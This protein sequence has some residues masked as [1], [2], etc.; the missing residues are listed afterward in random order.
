MNGETPL[1]YVD[2][3]VPENRN[4][5]RRGQRHF[6]SEEILKE[7]RPGVESRLANGSDLKMNGGADREGGDEDEFAA[8]SK[9]AFEAG[10]LEGGGAVIPL[11][12]KEVNCAT[13]AL[14]LLALWRAKN[15]GEDDS[16]SRRG[17]TG[18][19]AERTCSG[20]P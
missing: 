20:R 16:I 3:K 15:L 1:S 14:A 13:E 19:D 6:D 9:A 2:S 8:I 5:S 18:K 12:G 7:F 17:R 11:I 4:V 10:I